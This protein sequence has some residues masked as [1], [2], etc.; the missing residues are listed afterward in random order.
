MELSRLIILLL[1]SV[2][3][4]GCSEDERRPNIILFMVDDLGLQDTSVPFLGEKMILNKIYKTPNLERLA[5]EGVLFNQAYAYGSCTPSRVSLMTGMNATRHRVTNWT[6]YKDKKNPAEI[7][8]TLLKYPMWNV[9]GLNPLKPSK[10]A[11]HATALP[12]IL[13][14]NGYK[15]IHVGKAHFGAHGTLGADP[16]NLGFQINIGGHAAGAPASYYA[17]DQYGAGIEEWAVPGLEEIYSDSLFL[18]EALTVKA[19]EEIEQSLKESKPFFLNM[20]HYAVHTPLQSDP[21]FFK[22]YLDIGLDSIEASYASLV[23]GVDKSLGDLLDYIEKKEISE[24]TVI[25]F[26]S[27]NGGE[28]SSPPRGK[29]SVGHNHPLACGKATPYEGGIRVPMIIRWYGETEPGSNNNSLVHIQDLFST[30][31]SISGSEEIELIQTVD[32]VDLK[33]YL[34]SGNEDSSRALIWNYPNHNGTKAKEKCRWGPYSAIRE[35]NWKL[36]YFHRDQTFELYDLNNDISEISNLASINIDKTKELAEKL[37]ERL[38]EMD[39][40]LPVV[41][42]TGRT[43]PYPAEALN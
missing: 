18:T 43:V 12:S 11:V 1:A 19:I 29:L 10:H 25:I 5:S 35:D 36:I 42:S 34:S 16:V 26:I 38:I 3:L 9:N 4:L 31:L 32:G 28:C 17:E 13:K 7:T 2:L 39:A 8:D 40:Q 22:H 23:E 20:A 41:K 30:V 21:R 33:D 24:N 37:T 6:R 27:D 14:E 15:T